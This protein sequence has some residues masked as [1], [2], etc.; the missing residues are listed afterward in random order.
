M[1]DALYAEQL[2]LDKLT[3]VLVPLLQLVLVTAMV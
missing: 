3:L 2:A 1:L